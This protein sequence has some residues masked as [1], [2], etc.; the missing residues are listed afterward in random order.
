[1]STLPHDHHGNATPSKTSCFYSLAVMEKKIPGAWKG[2][3][4]IRSL[5]HL[6]VLKLLLWSALET[7]PGGLWMESLPLSMDLPTP[8]HPSVLCSAS[9]SLT[10]CLTVGVRECHRLSGRVFLRTEEVGRLLARLPLLL[11]SHLLPS[12]L[13]VVV[14]S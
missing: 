11:L 8:T 2:V 7:D 4:S 5:H 9:A 14:C 13:N 12:M 3:C 1:M 6:P 10:H